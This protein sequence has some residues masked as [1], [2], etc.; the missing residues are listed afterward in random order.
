MKATTTLRRTAYT[1]DAVVD[2][3]RDWAKSVLDDVTNLIMGMLIIVGCMMGIMYLVG[4][5]D[6][7]IYYL[8]ARAMSAAPGMSPN[9]VLASIGAGIYLPL[10]VTVSIL[11]SISGFRAHHD[12]ALDRIDDLFAQI[13]ESGLEEETARELIGLLSEIRNRGK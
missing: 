4:Y 13:E 2:F 6:E 8:T 1:A 11:F 10:A 7:I 9:M 12:D 5:Q 3:L